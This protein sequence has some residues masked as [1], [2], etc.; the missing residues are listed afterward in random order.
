LVDYRR[1]QADDGGSRLGIR[2]RHTG[3]A[4]HLLAEIIEATTCVLVT[5]S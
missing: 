2:H 4:T 3:K 1:Q 5:R